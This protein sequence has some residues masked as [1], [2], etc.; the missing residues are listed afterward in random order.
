[1]KY[2]RVFEPIVLGKTLFV[3]FNDSDKVVAF[4]T[5]TGAE[6]WR[7]YV[8]GPVRFPP[9]AQGG[10]VQIVSDD[11]LMYC[12]NAETG[13]EI[14]KFRGGPSDRRIL[15]NERLISTWPARGAPVLRDGTVYFAASIWPFM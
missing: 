7:A 5:K 3:G 10:K 1:M 4:D 14:W 9:A 15:G 8:D 13:A 2:D 12:V 11:G 6:K